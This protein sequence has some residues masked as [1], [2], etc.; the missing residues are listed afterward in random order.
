MTIR[1]GVLVSVSDALIGVAVLMWVIGW[2][3]NI[4]QTTYD[5]PQMVNIAAPLVDPGF[6][7]YEPVFLIGSPFL[8]AAAIYASVQLR[9][10]K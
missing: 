2:C 10:K 9:R 4:D 1:R 7:A 5:G 8:V 6:L 3:A